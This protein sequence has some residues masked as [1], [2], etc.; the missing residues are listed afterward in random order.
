MDDVEI[1]N[2]TKGALVASALT[3]VCMLIWMLDFGGLVY[4]YGMI[5]ETSKI[6]AVALSVAFIA[7]LFVS[8][9]HKKI[10][11]W[12]GL[13]CGISGCVYLQSISG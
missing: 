10:G 12:I 6:A 8:K 9:N 4:L 7:S 1:K 2:R 13:F 5:V 3:L 11:L